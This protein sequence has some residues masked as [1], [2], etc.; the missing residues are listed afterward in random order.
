MKFM[1]NIHYVQSTLLGAVRDTKRNQEDPVHRN[2]A[3]R[4]T[5][6]K[7]QKYCSSKKFPFI[8]KRDFERSVEEVALEHLNIGRILKC[9]IEGAEKK[10]SPAKEITQEAQRRESMTGSGR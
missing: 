4:H 6:M 9:V 2:K 1:S 3:M 7:A 5:K 10:A 8:C